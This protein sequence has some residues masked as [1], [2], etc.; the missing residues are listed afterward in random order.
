MKKPAKVASVCPGSKVLPLAVGNSWT[1]KNVAA[2]IDPP[3]GM[4]KTR[5]LPAQQIVV[6]VVGAEKKGEETTVKLQEKITYDITKD[7]GTPKSFVQTVE[8]TIVC[9]PKGKFNISPEAFFFAGEPGGYR[10]L[11]FT[12]FDRTKETSL[13]LTNG[14]IGDQEWLEEIAAEYEK[15]ATK[16][17]NAKLGKG[18]VELERK[19]T[20]EHPESIS[21][22]MGTFVNN[23]KLVVTTTG[24]I[25]LGEKVAPD[26]KSCSK[27]KE[28]PP[29]P[30]KPGE[31]PPEKGAEPQKKFIDEPTEVC[32]LPANWDSRLWFGENIGVVQA[33]NAFAHKYQLVEMKLN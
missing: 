11:A 4:T 12:R 29:D 32:E 18:K 33:E 27:K 30:P 6:S 7:S 22:A 15:H 10:G 8:S 1:Y 14:G 21:T 26:G 23:E 17:S 2:S 16:G 9:S 13:K 3:E 24:R 31:K 19:Y 5:P 25:H 20:P 28:V